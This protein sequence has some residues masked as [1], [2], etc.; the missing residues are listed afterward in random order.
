MI[1]TLM[2]RDP[3]RPLRLLVVEDHA[4]TRDMYREFFESE[5]CEVF[6][7]KDGG[8]GLRAAKDL[9]PDALVLDMALPVMDGLT[10]LRT[11][12]SD[13]DP[14]TA[15]VPVLIVSGSVEPKYLAAAAAA[16]ATRVLAKPCL[17]D[18]LLQAIR[19][20]VDPTA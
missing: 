1:A 17:P 4:D 18:H 11:L 8:E 15:R 2:P 19:D 16:G 6:T 10:L 9:S 3:L 12:R 5:G 13:P 14:A 20:A 7:A